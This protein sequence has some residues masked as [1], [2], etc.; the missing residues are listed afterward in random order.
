MEP[1]S[2]VQSHPVLQERGSDSI[3]TSEPTILSIYTTVIAMNTK[4]DVVLAKTNDHETRIRSLEKWKYML[5]TSF[6]TA[7]GGLGLGLFEF[8][9]LLRA[10]K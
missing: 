9:H 4:L 10:G 2:V 5:P 7:L 1:I 8:I 6:F 3:M